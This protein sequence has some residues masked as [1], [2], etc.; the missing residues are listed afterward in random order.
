MYCLGNSPLI[1][2]GRQK[3]V[4]WSKDHL[5]SSTSETPLNYGV[6]KAGNSILS[7]MRSC[8]QQAIA[9][10]SSLLS[11]RLLNSEAALRNFECRS[12]WCVGCVE[13]I[14]VS[15]AFEDGS[16]EQHIWRKTSTNSSGK[17]SWPELTAP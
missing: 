6:Q 13:G 15:R 17:T 16:A 7:G 2:H 10:K 8:Q 5:R 3:S 12:V 9:H 4:S 14:K 11:H 1:R